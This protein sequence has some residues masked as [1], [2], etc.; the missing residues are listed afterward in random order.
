MRLAIVGSRSFKNLQM[1]RD[2]VNSLP[3]TFIIVSGGAQGVDIV[4][5]QTAFFNKMETK[6]FYPEYIKFPENLRWKAPLE[7]NTQIVKFCDRLVAFWDGNSSGTADI[8][9]KSKLVDKLVGI[10]TDEL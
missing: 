6:I 5:E 1:V 10:F 7:R 2:F 4:A 9:R 8:I 3:S